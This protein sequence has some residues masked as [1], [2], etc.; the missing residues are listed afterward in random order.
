M[1]LIAA[2]PDEPFRN[3]EL[4]IERRLDDLLGRLTLD[5]KIRLFGRQPDLS[6]LGLRLTGHCE[7]IHG[8][9][10][11]GLANWVPKRQVPTTIFPQGYGLGET[12]DEDLLRRIG[13][14]EG[15]EARYIYQSPEYR[16]GALILLTPNA[17]LGR[18]PRWGRTEE[19]YGE[20]PF[21]AARLT[22]AMV[23]GLQGDDPRRLLTAS[24]M[25]H[26]LANSNEDDRE[27]SSSNFDERLWREYY[28]YAFWKGATEGGAQAYMAAY[29]AWNGV[30]CHVH[31][32]HREMVRKDWKFDGFVCTDGG[33]MR[34]LVEAHKA[35]ATLEEAAAA[36]V[37]AGISR[38]LD[39]FEPALRGALARGL[40]S[41]SDLNEGLRPFLRVQCRLGLLDPPGSGPYESILQGP[42]PWTT[43]EHRA[44][45]LEA[46][47]KSIVL[48]KN[49][50]LL[51][52]DPKGLRTLAVVGRHS[53]EVLLDWYSGLPPYRVSPLRGIRE[54]LG[55]DCRVLHA[56]G[57]EEALKA[58]R[59]A[60]VVVAIV[61]N[62]PV[63]TA[64]WAKV[65]RPSEGKEGIDR[66]TLA[67]EDEAFLRRLL[68]ANPRTVV[69]LRSSFPYAIVWTQENA[70]AI[71]HLAHNGQEEGTALARALFGDDNPAGRLTQ[72]WVRSDADLPPMM[73]YD[74]RHGRTY[75]YFRGRPLYPFG[76]GLSYTRFDY[77]QLRAQVRGGAIEAEVTVRNVGGRDGE[78]VA[79]LYASFPS[80]RVDRPH[81]QLVGF[82]RLPIRAGE[83]ATV[84]LTVPLADLAFW[85]E[86]ERRW[87][88]EGGAVRLFAGP[89]SAT[90]ATV[91]EVRVPGE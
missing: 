5:E 84:R 70:P 17:D 28:A 29:N 43:Q 6:R 71:L 54:R 36:V 41:E 44:L 58:A 66:R 4:P 87:V 24:L 63:G 33:G 49:D 7:G 34:L 46:S 52:L 65:E 62:E 35:A 26:F 61:G 31:P 83:A 53:D 79:Q 40:L 78:E 88:V 59:E 9:S 42:E 55:G 18:D 76:F 21:L 86:T 74:I 89:D 10:Q 13:R 8:L 3:P 39:N 47:R 12:W 48:L 38:F 72:T 85:S 82:R 56:E 32:M 22:V 50:G 1:N 91:A 25:K 19:C 64:G 45:A 68:E 73:D 69:V 16:Q 81:R 14:A 57:G 80:S 23:R 51:P 27:R 67:L 15:T 60:D 90:E 30:P 37:R 11:G 2:P 75:R 20:D 77:G